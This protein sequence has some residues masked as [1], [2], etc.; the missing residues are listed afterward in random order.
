MNDLKLRAILVANRGEI[1]CRIIQT[2]RRLGIR[3]VA[4]YS[5]VDSDS[6]HVTAADESC[7]L[8]GDPTTAYLDGEQIISIAKARDTQAIIPGYGFLSENAAFARAVV[9]AGLIFVG[10]P[11]EAIETFGVKHTARELAVAAGVPVVPGSQGL[12]ETEEAAAS[13]AQEIGYPVMLKAT[14]GGGGMGLF[15]CNDESDLRRNFATAKSRGAAL[16]KDAGVFL[17]RYIPSSRHIEVQVFGNGLGHA[18][19]F[20]ER[21]CSIQR[22]HQKLVEECPSPFVVNKHPALREKLTSCAVQLAKSVK[23]G[24]L[25]TVEFLVD[26]ETGDFFFLEMN[27]RIQVE[28]GITELCY[29][30]DLVELMLRQADRELQGLGGLDDGVLDS[31]QLQALKPNG[32]AIEVRLCAENPARDFAPSPGLLQE[33]VWHRLSGTRVD[34]WARAGTQIGIGYD[35]L[36]AKVMQWSPDRE[37]TIRELQEVL[38][39][40]TIRGPPT[41]LEFLRQLARDE[42]FLNGQTTTQFLEA[43]KP[44]FSGIEVISGGSYTLVQDYPGRPTVGH[45]FGHAGPMDPIALQAANILAGN[46]VGTEGL[47][48]TLTGPELLFVSDAIVALC[49]PVIPAQLDGQDFPRWTRSLIRAGQRLTMGRM[50]S[51]CRVYLAVHGGFTNVAVWLGS[52][53][54]NPMTGIGGYQGRPLRTGDFLATLDSGN[55]PKVEQKGIPGHLVPSYTNAPCWHIQVMPGPYETGYLSERGLEEFY[56]TPWEVSH[57]AARG[58]IRLIGP[59][60]H[61][62]RTDGGDGGAHPS[63][64]IEYGYPIGGINWTGDEAVIFPVDCPDFGGFICSATVVNADMWKLGQL[65]PGDVVRFERTSLDDALEQRRRQDEYLRQLERGLETGWE[66]CKEFDTGAIG[67][68]ST[69]SGSDVV[70]ELQATSS[71]P[72]VTYRCG[73]DDYLLV[74]YG[75][76]RFDLNHKCRATALQKLIEQTDGLVS[77]YDPAG[78]GA[79]VN[80]V[81]CGNSLAIT[82]NGLKLPRDL[83]VD[84]LVKLED[85]L[86]DMRHAKL[87][88]RRFRLPVTFT[89]RKLGECIERYTA[90][91]RSLASY[92]PDPFAFLAEANDMTPTELKQTLLSLESIIIGVGFFM[93]LPLCLPVDPRHRLRSPKMNPSRT[94]TPEGTF[95][96]GGSCIAVYPVD[97]PGGYMP[98]GMTIPGLDL[99]GAKKGFRPQTP[100]MFDSMDV[101]CFY[102]VGE[103]EYDAKMAQFRAGMYEFEV[104]QSVF[105]MAEHNRLLE[106]TAAEA[107]RVASSRA[108]AQEQMAHR[109]EECLAKWREQKDADRLQMNPAVSLENDPNL[110]IIRAPMTANVWKVLVEEGQTLAAGQVVAILEAMKM[111]VNVHADQ[112][113]VAGTVSKVLVAPGDIVEGGRPM[114]LVQ[115]QQA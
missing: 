61:F 27:T 77:L 58:G 68:S 87:P 78:V 56:E 21:E 107:R 37:R 85:G 82:Y 17:E 32:H 80:M 57:N 12:L 93:A 63:N 67:A 92:L 18:I 43:F 52:K 14:A 50:S 2:C 79:I 109:E 45:G 11:S 62:A 84:T 73:G 99:Y 5:S 22:R 102:E 34:T 23:Y 4:V 81:G 53:S 28:H 41:N 98:L 104:E 39:G 60:P 75:D 65:R 46:P 47:E 96:W 42:T 51:G 38:D 16:F 94:Y 74:D 105:D 113:L 29:G 64:V 101:V 114:M 100:W 24:S 33:V 76:G 55:L 8:A 112:K 54:T 6:L 86:G 70:K 44:N 25:G 110:Q 95:S 72:N 20:G 59:R 88:N 9:A 26:D 19:S 83:L 15:V 69:N 36:I 89:H 48:I 108:V 35:P 30:L 1:A 90:N 103:D 111:E 13:S 31:L 115:R 97:C 106:D 3:T 7:L 71:R 40:S 49:G 10:P 66:G 91:Q